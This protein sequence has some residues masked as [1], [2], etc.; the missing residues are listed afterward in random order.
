MKKILFSALI[1]SSSVSFSQNTTVGEGFESVSTNSRYFKT[2]PLRSLFGT[3]TEGLE[4][5][6]K[7]AKDRVGSRER[8]EGF[9]DRG[10]PENNDIDPALQITPPTQIGNDVFQLKENFSGLNGGT[11]PDPSGA[12]GLNHYIQ[13]KNT[14]FKIYDKDGSTAQTPKN[15]S[16]LWSGSDNE[17]DPIVMYDRYADR[18]F[19]SQFQKSD[20]NG[21]TNQILIAISESADPL[22]S[23]HAYEYE[24]NGIF[25]DYPKFGVWSNGYYMSANCSSNNCAVFERE[26][27][28]QG[29]TAQVIKMSFPSSVKH[30]GFW[31]ASPAYAEGETAP[32]PNAPFYFFHLQ[33]DNWPGV[34]TGNDHIKAIKLVTNWATPSASAFSTQSIPTQAFNSAFTSSWDDL[35]QGGT[36]QKLDGVP[37]IFMYR[38]QY[39]RFDGYNVVLLCTT[40]DVNGQ[41][42]AGIRWFELRE[43]NDGVWYIYQESTFD[44][45]G[46]NNRWLGSMGMD[47]FGNIAMA[48]SFAGPNDFAGLRYTGRF[49]NDP[50]N[51]MTV[52]ER[53]AVEGKG[54]QN[55]LNRFGD[56]AQMTLDPA[57]D[58]TF[59]YTGEYLK[60]NGSIK[61][62]IFAF[63]AWQLLDTDEAQELIPSFKAFQPHYGN[64]TMEWSDIEDTQ[65]E[66]SMFDINGKLILND[67][68]NTN[69]SSKTYNSSDFSKGIYIVKLTGSKTNI[70]RKLYL[71]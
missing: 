37:T 43:N 18:W 26:K 3:N 28:L 16:Y 58:Y 23:Y 50:L 7:E 55:G 12:A 10:I 62:R 20:I 54:A 44:P 41:N 61:T 53:V 70:S 9:V 30:V 42:R 4:D 71:N 17:G 45:D 65:L 60:N 63:Q 2:P 22:G 8:P 38:T 19:I 14:S 33:D 34:A 51:Q 32:E 31:S 64:L 15:L 48:Y 56:Y 1:L 68:I 39:R 57:D 52:N 40:V 59:W 47:K 6:F 49:K 67:K 66:I 35:V 46:I 29:Q 24:W 21:G 11:P 25:P 13:A 27:M 5:V 36:S 69:E